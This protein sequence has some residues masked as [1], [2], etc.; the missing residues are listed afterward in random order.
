MWYSLFRFKNFLAP[1]CSTGRSGR[2]RG[3]VLMK[4]GLGGFRVASSATT[5]L[6]AIASPSSPA[7]AAPSRP[8]AGARNRAPI[9]AAVARCADY[10][11]RRGLPPALRAWSASIGPWTVVSLLE[12]KWKYVMI[13]Q[14]RDWPRFRRIICDY[15]SGCLYDCFLS[16]PLSVFIYFKEILKISKIP[17]IREL[18]NID[19]YVIYSMV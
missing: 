14:N 9:A 3:V 2:S 6:V 13:G 11:R 10:A 1:V 8:A 18:E 15:E 4:W 12:Y 16:I 19:A 7:P 17:K 5:T